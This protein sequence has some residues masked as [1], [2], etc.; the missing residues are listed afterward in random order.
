MP[1]LARLLDRDA[2]RAV[3]AR[4]L[5]DGAALGELAI[6]RV[7]YKPGETVAVHYEGAVDGTRHD[8]VATCIAGVDLAARARMPRYRALAQRPNGRSPAAA[9][10]SYDDETGALVSSLPFDPRLPALAEDAPELS[11]RLGI[12]LPE[13]LELIGYK[14][15]SRAVLRGDGHVLK[16]C[17]AIARSGR[18]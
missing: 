11:R 17:G 2:M 16:A 9:T 18:R 3:L 1:K 13:T 5:P 8:A 4:S 15:R 7:I 10:I 6:G 12:A 14:P